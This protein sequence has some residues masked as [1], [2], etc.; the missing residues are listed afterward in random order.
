MGDQNE[1]PTVA[2][3][4]ATYNGENY[5]A[6]QL[7][8]IG[9]QT[10]K[11]WH[12]YVSDD[13]SKDSTL[14][15][16][17]AFSKLNP[18]KVTI[19]PAREKHDGACGNFFNLVKKCI[20]KAEYYAFSDQD[21][22]WLK[23]KLDKQVALLDN[24]KSNFGTEKP[25]LAFCDACLVDENLNI[26]SP[27]FFTYTDVNPR[28]T[29]LNRI[30]VQNPISGAGA[31]I[32]ESLLDLMATV[33]DLSGIAMYDQWAGL[34]ASALGHIDHISEP[35]YLYR[36]H[37][38]NAMGAVQM[39]L[40]SLREK[41][42]IAKESLKS[43]ELQVAIFVKNYGYLLGSQGKSLEKYSD[44]YRANKL[45]RILYILRYKIKMNGFFRNL[46]LIV[47]V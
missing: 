6:D 13:G 43:K 27:S 41:G 46:G 10:Y 7:L 23:D 17:Q 34:I 28:A 33:N 2:I 12:L 31:L 15:I 4:M 3:L 22:V 5:I 25:L 9:W 11:N 42:S 35:L 24:L 38:N 29:S 21:D 44:L 40:S 36:Q 47:Y 20:G 19:L 26:I 18:G 45:D 8:S 32:N 30:I 1:E 14:A 37:A 16:V 39:S